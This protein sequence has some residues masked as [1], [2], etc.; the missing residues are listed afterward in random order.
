[1]GD[2][3]LGLPRL[4]VTGFVVFERRDMLVGDLGDGKWWSDG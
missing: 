3:L 2:S 4:G 1:M